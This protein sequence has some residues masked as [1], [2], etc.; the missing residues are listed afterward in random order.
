[1]KTF[2]AVLS[3]TLLASTATV[4]TSSDS[5]AVMKAVLLYYG[6]RA[7]PERIGVIPT[8]FTESKLVNGRQ[9]G[10]RWNTERRPTAMAAAIA[11]NPKLRIVPI[12][13]SIPRDCSKQ[14]PKAEGAL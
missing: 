8:T 6:E 14:P 9:T 7:E 5:S 4:Q 12:L 3:F 1:M 2:I 10:F 13:D 11:A